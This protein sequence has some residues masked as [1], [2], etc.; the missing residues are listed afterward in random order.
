MFVSSVRFRDSASRASDPPSASSGI[1]RPFAPQ[2]S[3][4][5]PAPPQLLPPRPTLA[6]ASSSASAT[7]S[8]SVPLAV[9]PERL[10][11]PLAYTS[12]LPS[13]LACAAPPLAGPLPSSALLPR[14]SRADVS[15]SVQPPDVSPT[16]VP[17]TPDQHHVGQ[18]VPVAKR[19]ARDFFHVYDPT[20]FRLPL[21]RPPIP[22]LVSVSAPVPH[23]EWDIDPTLLSSPVSEE[24][25]SI[26]TSMSD[27]SA[28]LLGADSPRVVDFTNL[29][30]QAV[31]AASQI[32]GEEEALK[33]AAGFRWPESDRASDLHDFIACDHSL[34]R[35]AASRIRLAQDQQLLTT[36]RAVATFHPSNPHLPMVLDVASGV[37]VVFPPEFVPNSMAPSPP[38]PSPAYCKLATVVD[39]AY[40]DTHGR[41]HLAV[42]LPADVVLAHCPAFHT[43][44]LLWTTKV[45]KVCGRSLIDPSWSDALHSPL[46]SEAARDM[47]RDRWG[48]IN[49]P[50]IDEVVL[51]VIAAQT[52]FPHDVIVLWL[53]DVRGAYTQLAFHP[54][55]VKWMAARLLCGA[56]LFFLAGIFGWSGMPFAFDC[57][58]RAIRWELA[59]RL[60]GPSNIF[61]DDAMGA[62]PQ[63]FLHD[64]INTCA[65][66][67]FGAMGPT[68]VEPNKTKA[69]SA[70]DVIGYHIDLSLGIVSIAKKNVLRALHGFMAV[71]F[72]EPLPVRTME[73]LASWAARYSAI[74]IV[75]RPFATILF[76]A[77]HRV[78]PRGFVKLTPEIR[79]AILLFQTLLALTVLRGLACARTISSFSVHFRPDQ[80]PVLMF[81]ASLSGVG[82]LVYIWSRDTA[83][84]RPVGGASISILSLNF[85]GKPQFQN[86]AEL[87]AALFA[88]KVAH[89][90]SC[91][92]SYVWLVGDSISALSWAERW[93]ANSLLAVNAANVFALQGLQ[94][95]LHV[96][97]CAHIEGSQHW[98]CDALSRHSSW[99]DFQQSDHAWSSI[100]ETTFSPLVTANILR[101]CDPSRPWEIDPTSWRSA[102][103]AATGRASV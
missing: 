85:V 57:V 46:N 53:M 72:S 6:H 81:D 44:R 15:L 102:L 61:V 34:E 96:G 2:L 45:N 60:H 38:P 89:A 52:K 56:F 95:G 103:A 35:L 78:S 62:T 65:A 82:V 17:G 5:L 28:L 67:M 27:I 80:C 51:M 48:P 7:S 32:Y 20:A 1:P 40:Y 16:Q 100:S 13:P 43:S 88:V 4:P 101:S 42:V 64:D 36:A 31:T 94:L 9:P 97:E 29:A 49:N 24:L 30:L 47:C 25:A 59:H 79:R 93:A 76:S 66:I 70:L 33:W 39:K 14:G 73:R 8:C 22:V 18:F 98:R 55:S 75:M 77:M 68:A 54:A 26:I 91:N 50:S 69:S 10:P 84:L 21:L 99:Q 41:N 87:I 63:R 71:S 12:L 3:R 11:A 23:S 58:T 74:C 90:L 19:R 37:T 92:L 83:A 86:V